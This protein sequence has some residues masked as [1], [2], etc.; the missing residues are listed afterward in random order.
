MDK[1]KMRSPYLVAENIKILLSIK[2]V[3]GGR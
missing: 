3:V 1:L 2:M